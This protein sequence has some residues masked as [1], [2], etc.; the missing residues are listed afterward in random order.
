MTLSQWKAAQTE[1]DTLNLVRL[2][3][4]RLSTATP[5][6]NVDKARPPL[7]DQA[8]RYLKSIRAEVDATWTLDSTPAE[9]K[10]DLDTWVAAGG[11]T[12]GIMQRINKLLPFWWAYGLIQDFV[13]V[14]TVSVAQPPIITY[15]DSPAVA[16]GWTDFLTADDRQ[17]YKLMGDA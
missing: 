9:I 6:A 5:Q 15:D 12:A 16:N 1:R 11:T 13:A 7:E 10:T 8:L 14:D 3:L 4:L 2:A 17:K